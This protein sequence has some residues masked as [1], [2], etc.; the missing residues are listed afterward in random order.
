MSQIRTPRKE[1]KPRL[2]PW[3]YD[4][5]LEHQHGHWTAKEVGDL[6]RDCNTCKLHAKPH[7]LHGIEF[8]LASFVPYEIEVECYWIGRM[9]KRFPHPEL[10]GLFV[11]IGSFEHIHTDG[12]DQL[13]VSWDVDLSKYKQ[14]FE[15]PLFKERRQLI[16][17]A[18]N[19]DDDMKS[20]STMALVEGVALFAQFAYLQSFVKKG[21]LEQLDNLIEWSSRDEGSIHLRAAAGIFRELE[22]EGESLDR[23]W[24][25]NQCQIFFQQE[26]LI[27]DEMF[28]Y[29]DPRGITKKDLIEFVKHRINYV[30]EWLGFDPVFNIENTVVQKWFYKA[31][32]LPVD[33]DGFN[34]RITEYGK[35]YNFSKWWERIDAE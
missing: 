23:N 11:T 13:L 35:G 25:F 10:R 8:L 17:D 32:H 2:Y 16:D 6:T 5:T 9:W 33:R 15:S 21:L 1:Y 34:S 12:Y 3:A 29:G 27:V 4:L 20:I 24:W 18:L 14:F 26:M 7:E 28:K 22:K 31:H 19:G 30:S